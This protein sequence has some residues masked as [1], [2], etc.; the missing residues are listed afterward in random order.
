MRGRREE[1]NSYSITSKEET[2]PNKKNIKFPLQKYVECESL[3]GQGIKDDNL[4][5]KNKM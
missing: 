2:K 3:E 1:Q 5:V 4:A